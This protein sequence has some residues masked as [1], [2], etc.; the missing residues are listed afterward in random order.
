MKKAPVEG[1]IILNQEGQRLNML[2]GWGNTPGWVWPEKAKDEIL[3]ESAAWELQP[4]AIQ[5][6]RYDPQDGS[7]ET[8]GELVSLRP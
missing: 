7:V 1:Y 5:P 6:A 8:L 2:K 4:T 3:Q